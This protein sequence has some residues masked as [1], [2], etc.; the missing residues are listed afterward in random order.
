[1]INN[2]V[3]ILDVSFWQDDDYTPYKIDF[4]R[5]W[6]AGADG[7]IL[8]AGQNAWMDEDYLDYCRNADEA[9]LPRGAYWFF[10]SRLSPIPQAD[11]FADI[12]E[13]SGFPQLGVWGDYE[14]NYGGLYGGETNFRLFMDKLASRFPGKIVGVYT[15]P[16]YWKTRTTISGREYF[17][18]F[19]LWIANY[20]VNAPD[21]PRPWDFYTFWQYTAEGDGLSF[22]A[23]SLEID[24]NRFGGTLD[25]YRN[26]FSLS[27]YEPYT[28]QAPPQGDRMLIYRIKLT[29][30]P[31]VNL[32]E[33]ADQN[34]RDLGDMFPGEEFLVD[35]GAT[36]KDSL[37]RDW[38]RSV[39]P[40]RVGYI[41]ASLC[42]FV[43]EANN[44]EPTPDPE[45]ESH[46]L[47]VYMDGVLEYRKEF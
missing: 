27:N 14:E 32:R 10:D 38:L 35:G 45:P 39:Q 33:D 41:L 18:K 23:E 37:G 29:A 36:K 31:H 20:G 2:K 24:M 46:V 12:V 4:N 17:K 42:E 43:R 8:R 1:M 47:E 7:V 34:A 22:G 6:V 16:S 5:S 15:G 19:P 44:G 3:I 40:G 26:M 30:T 21:V 25:E 28:E 11:L 9:G 13:A